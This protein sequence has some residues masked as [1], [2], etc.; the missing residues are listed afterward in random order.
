MKLLKL[1]QISILSLS[2]FLLINFYENFNEVSEYININDDEISPSCQIFSK[3]KEQIT[4]ENLE[5][6][7][8]EITI[9]DSNNWYKNLFEASLGYLV[10]EEKHKKNFE[11]NLIV[12]VVGLDKKCSY[13]S[14]VRVSGLVSYNVTLKPGFT[15]MDLK[16][17]N[18]NFLGMTSFK[19]FLPEMRRFDNEIL[20]TTLLKHLGHLSPNTFWKEVSINGQKTLFLIQEEVNSDFLINNSLREGPILEANNRLSLEGKSFTSDTAM[21]AKI[22]NGKWLDSNVKNIEISQFAIEKLNRLNIF[23]NNN[24][25]FSLNL[26]SLS[27]ENK[28]IFNEFAIL[29][30]S[31]GGKEA[32]N[33]DDRKF[34]F[35]P[36]TEIIYPVYY[37][38]V[39]FLNLNSKATYPDKINLETNFEIHHIHNLTSNL[40][41][42]TVESLVSKVQRFNYEEFLIDLK[43]RGLDITAFNFSEEEF[44]EHFIEV[45][46]DHK[47]YIGDVGQSNFENYISTIQNKQERYYLLFSNQSTYELCNSKLVCENYKFSTSELSKILK[48]ERYINDRLV[49]YVGEKKFINKNNERSFVNFKTHIINNSNQKIYYLGE[50]EFNYKDDILNIIQNSPDFKVLIKDENVNFSIKFQNILDYENEYERYDSDLLT[51]CINIYNSTLDI[52]IIEITNPKCEDGINIV[53][54]TGKVSFINIQNSLNDS[55]D[56]DFSD[57]E[58]IDINIQNSKNDCIDVSSGKYKID[59]LN[60]SYCQDKA[61]SVGENSEVFVNRI[62]TNHSNIGIAVKDSSVVNIINFYSEDDEYCVQMYRK[63]EKFGL[64]ELNINNLFCRN[65][66]IY[67]G[68]SNRFNG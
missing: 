8:I 2:S 47:K 45:I 31:L 27:E 51:G 16:I 10:I 57:L 55:I 38:G 48:G 20:T 59:T 42:E 19:L 18:D 66:E 7:E 12:S 3:G 24:Y 68:K 28:K 54:S 23:R 41:L 64:S 17:E 13:K 30:N 36:V 35:E 44:K 5:N 63:K 21:F 58:I 33:W 1:L 60:L 37:D 62:L 65:G 15:S 34:Y 11:S 22:V 29:M 56:L 6:L 39:D 9:P 67:I 43:Q 49:F 50:G 46:N 32:L 4:F 53:Q 40:S 25:R 52:K 26:N 61:M 14:K